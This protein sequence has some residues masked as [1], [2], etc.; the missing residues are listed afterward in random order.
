MLLKA[1]KNTDAARFIAIVLLS[2]VGVLGLEYTGFYEGINNYCY[3]M[4]FRLH[5]S[6]ENNNRIIIAAIDEKTL[7]KLG[8]WPIRRSVY[9]D[10]LV[11]LNQAT[12]VGIDIIFSEPS[13]DDVR[14][15][16]TIRRHNRVVLPVY[17][18]RQFDISHPV[19]AFS[20]AGVGH[21]HLEKGLDGFVREVFHTITCQSF[22]FASFASAMQKVI[23]T[24]D[25][26]S[27]AGVPERVS[28]KVLEK[29]IQSDR[30]RINFYGPRETFKYYSVVDILDGR[31]PPS[32]FT[33][34]IVIVG[35]TTAGI[36]DSLWIPFTS[37][38]NGMP[39][40]E[41]H[42]HILNNL[43][44]QSHIREIAR[45]TRWLAVT[46]WAG[47]CFCLFIRFGSLGGM[48]VGFLSLAVISSIVFTC[49]TTLNLWLAPAS[50]YFATAAV[51]ILAIIFN[52]QK[53]KRLLFQAKED[54]EES[55]NTIDDAITIHQADGDIIRANKAAEQNFGPPLLNFLRQRCL[56]VCHGDEIP[57]T[58]ENQWITSK[59]MTEEVF[60]ARLDRNLEI[61]SLP[62]FDS[63]GRL[64]GMVQVVRDISEKKKTEKEHALLRSQLIEAQKM[65]AIGTLA[66]GIAHDFNNILA[67]VMGYTE[68]SLQ[69][70]PNGSPVKNR[71]QQVLKASLRAKEL[72]D[73]ILAFRRRSS[74]ES[75]P[76]TTRIRLIIK[77][78]LKL[79]RSTLPS[80]ILIRP[81]I[82]SD[83]CAII[84]P[85]R[86][87][88]IIMN[89]CTN[90]KHAMQETGGT[91]TVELN[92][93]DI[94]APPEL[95]NFDPH[96]PPGPYVMLIVK[97]NG[98]GMAPDIRKRI[99]EPYFT[100]KEKGVGTGLGLTTV[101][102]I[103]KNHGGAISVESEVGEGTVVS[104]YLPRTDRAQKVSQPVQTPPRASG[105]ERILFIDDEEELVTIGRDMLQ[106]LGYQVVTKSNGLDALKAFREKPDHFDLV[107]TDMT[108]PKMTGERLAR[109]L[110]KI[111][112]NIT[113]ILCT[114]YSEQINA[115]K[116]H[117]IGISAFVRKPLT[118]MRLA[119]A[120][121][122]V[123]DHQDSASDRS[124]GITSRR[125]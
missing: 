98:H 15:A 46:V 48:L 26:A 122:N 95:S 79:L 99:F 112:P 49:F 106:H 66:G 91:L 33:D 67:A 11:I 52:L 118:L 62:R 36:H 32:F 12:V 87:H 44:D 22:I 50:F 1:M 81:N 63:D 92:D 65:E 19:E 69:D 124:S 73:Q 25:D 105:L 56:D 108:M 53:M 77:E 17:I 86:V 110:I 10:L 76:Q 103:V 100:T 43:L 9:S 58:V 42:A 101:H 71:L 40:A 29:I 68:L 107:V 4:M 111:R 82:T 28:S 37:G 121:R 123:L 21:V 78:A 109:E 6:R 70:T 116:A 61:K 60:N 39:S 54:W 31:W 59:G 45:E 96:L 102:A 3:D 83:G 23:N 80:T 24:P 113:V 94:P 38:R 90:A 93:I 89:L 16:R 85:T 2:I 47:L 30:M 72:V 88:Q 34:K 104:I 51:F 5:G 120:V 55:F 13:D 97:D 74:Q 115:E 8:R 27:R 125:D 14:L 119:E 114:G 75:Q 35:K 64:K 20:V 57:G 18:D 7:L 41:V 117:A 84:D